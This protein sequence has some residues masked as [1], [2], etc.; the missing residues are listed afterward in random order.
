MLGCVCVCGCEVV[1]LCGCAVV[2]LCGCVVVW[3]CGCVVAC[4]D[5]RQQQP[6]LALAVNHLVV[7]GDGGSWSGG[8]R[9]KAL[10]SNMCICERTS[11]MEG[12]EL[13]VE[14]SEPR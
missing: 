7:G 3:L 10:P 12:W 11:S 6:S 1:G 8:P 5:T 2:W 14:E 13:S 4:R 9:L